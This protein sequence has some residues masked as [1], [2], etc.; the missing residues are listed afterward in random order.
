[1][2][3][4]AYDDALTVTENTLKTALESYRITKLQYDNGTG[5]E[6]DLRQ[7][8]GVV[9]EARAN[10]Q[11]QSR[12]RAQHFVSGP[13][14]FILCRGEDLVVKDPSETLFHH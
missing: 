9:E 7:S 6:L 1:M 11:T 12:L 5:T 14:P 4:L 10:L 2:T 3:I 13:Q 8:E